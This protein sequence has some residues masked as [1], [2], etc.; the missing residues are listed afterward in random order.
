MLIGPNEV[1]I[2]CNLRFIDVDVLFNGRKKNS[3][4]VSFATEAYVGKA[5]QNTNA[6]LWHA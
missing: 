3:L 1:R 4:Y 5:S 6:L 2:L